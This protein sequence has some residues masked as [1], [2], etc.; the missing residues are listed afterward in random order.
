LCVIGQLRPDYDYDEWE[1]EFEA[2]QTLIDEYQD[3][4]DY[5]SYIMPCKVRATVNQGDAL[6][7]NTDMWHRGGAHT[8]PDAP[9]RAVLFLSL[10]SS[11]QGPDDHRVLSFGKVYSL[12]WRMWGQTIEDFG[13]MKERRWRAWHAFGLFN[14]KDRIRPFTLIDAFLHIYQLEGNVGDFV[15]KTFSEETVWDFTIVLLMYSAFAAVVYVACALPLF[16]CV[17]LWLWKQE[18]KNPSD[19][20]TIGAKSKID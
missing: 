1:K 4:D 15:S 7:Y 10:A 19:H 17:I 20:H 14:G 2:N 13:T 8:D 18:E 16:I 12:D 6:F 11:R 3:F 9:E 5:A